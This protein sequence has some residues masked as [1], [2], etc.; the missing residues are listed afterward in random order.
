MANVF[1]TATLGLGVDTS[2]FI[3][4]MSGAVNVTKT[5]LNQMRLGAEA[6]ESQWN[7]MTD[8][9][10]D[11]R[12]IISG[13]L[14]SQGFYSLMNGLTFGA[15]EALT[16]AQ[17]MET[18]AVS[19]EYFVDGADKA[20]K[21][22]AF[23]REMN[24]FAARTPFSTEQALEMSKY[25]QAVG[26]SMNTSKA[27]LEVVTDAAAATGATEENL[28]RVIFA[29][30]QMQTKGRVANEEIRQLANANIPIY[31]ILQ[32]E[33][34]LTGDQISNIGKYWIDADKAIVAILRGLE[35][36]YDGAA[37]RI[38]D[39]MSGMIDTIADNS[40]IIAQAAGQGAYDGL[41]NVM[42]GVRDMLD[43][44]RDTVTEFGSA[45][46]FNQILID[47]DPTGE[48]GTQVLTLIG[49][50]RQLGAAAIDL[51]HAAQP[52]VGLFGK[53]LYAGVGSLTVGMTGL[54][55]VAEGVV[56]VLNELG[57]TSGTT[58]EVL[59][60]LYITYKVSRW[61]ISLGQGALFAMQGMYNAASGVWAIVP[62]TVTASS[63][64]MRLVG[65]LGILAAVG[66]AAFALFNNLD[67]FAGLEVDT[68]GMFPEDYN[69]A[70]DEYLAAMEEYNAAIEKY[71]Q[72][73]NAP[74]E[75]IDDGADKAITD[76]EDVED[77][78]KKAAK[79][80][81]KDWVAAFD[82][83]YQVPDQK[84]T[85]GGSGVE[86]PEMPDLGAFL[87]DLAFKFP[88]VGETELT[89]PE[90]PWEDVFS[91]GL[92]DDTAL[93]QDFWK[94]W[95]PG[96]I[97]MSL[98][99][100]AAMAAKKRKSRMDI[101]A[102]G[103][104]T[105]KPTTDMDP[106]KAQAKVQEAL[107]SQDK[108][109]KKIHS[110]TKEI[111]K[112]LNYAKNTSYG[113]EGRPTTGLSGTVEQQRLLI[114][115]YKK[116]NDTAAKYGAIVG[117]KVDTL[118]AIAEDERTLRSAQLLIN[119]QRLAAIERELKASGLTQGQMADLL[120]EQK[121]L[122]KE[123]TKL[124]QVAQGTDI[125]GFTAAE[126][127]Q[128]MLEQSSGIVTGLNDVLAKTLPRRGGTGNILTS[129][130]VKKLFSAIDDFTA[131]G[132]DL[133]KMLP[134]W[135]SSNATQAERL[136]NYISSQ[137]KE[138]ASIRK[139][140]LSGNVPAIEAL[141]RFT[142]AVTDI[143]TSSITGVNVRPQYEALVEPVQDAVNRLKS[144]NGYI[145]RL[146]DEAI[147]LNKQ[148]AAETA[149]RKAASEAAAAAAAEQQRIAKETAA[150]AKRLAAREA[151]ANIS[152]YPTGR[153][154]AGML[155]GLG[156]RRP[157]EAIALS[158]IIALDSRGVISQAVSEI[159]AG[160]KSIE[161]SSLSDTAS[162]KATLRAI[163]ANMQLIR[164]NGGELRKS[165]D[166][167]V[168][169]LARQFG[170]ELSDATAA[171]V[172]KLNTLNALVAGFQDILPSSGLASTAG[173]AVAGGN[174]PPSLTKLFGSIE[175]AT[176]VLL[177]GT[178]L[179]KATLGI[180]AFDGSDVDLIVKA[181]G[182][183]FP[184][185]KRL[186]K[187]DASFAVEIAKVMGNYLE[188]LVAFAAQ[189]QWQTA[190]GEV[191]RGGYKAIADG[192]AQIDTTVKYN[193]KLLSNDIKTVSGSAAEA[194]KQSSKELLGAVRSLDADML[195]LVRP[196]HFYQLGMQAAAFDDTRLGMTIFN[197][198][199][200]IRD[201]ADELY[202]VFIQKMQ[203]FVPDGRIFS[204]DAVSR[205]DAINAG[206][207]GSVEELV[208]SYVREV[209]LPT[210]GIPADAFD[211]ALSG[212][213]EEL[214]AFA[215]TMRKARLD[216]IGA[217][218]TPYMVSYSDAQIRALDVAGTSKAVKQ[219]NE[220]IAAVAH[221]DALPQFLHS[222]IIFNE[223]AGELAGTVAAIDLNSTLRQYRRM[224]ESATKWAQNILKTSEKFDA[225]AISRKL[226][227]A[228]DT[229]VNNYIYDVARLGSADATALTQKTAEQLRALAA[230]ARQHVN[231]AAS[232][233]FA[234]TSAT[235]DNMSLFARSLETLADNLSDTGR[236]ASL[237][238]TVTDKI[239]GINA[240]ID[241]HA[242]V[243]PSMQQ[244]FTG[245]G[246]NLEELFTLL[247]M[248]SNE[249]AIG[250][251]RQIEQYTAIAKQ[252]SGTQYFDELFG[253][254]ELPFHVASVKESAQ[255]T[256]KVLSDAVND[257]LLTVADGLTK[258]FTADVS[259]LVPDASGITIKFVGDLASEPLKIPASLFF[260]FETTDLITQTPGGAIMPEITQ[261][262]LLNEKTGEIYNW[263]IDHGERNAEILAR[264]QSI[265]GVGEAWRAYS[266]L[267]LANGVSLNQ[268]VQQIKGL[269]DSLDGTLTGYNAVNLIHAGGGFDAQLLKSLGIDLAD[270]FSK[271]VMTQAS[272]IMARYTGSYTSM[273][274]SSLYAIATGTQA[275][276][277]H[278]AA[279]DV[280][281]TAAIQQAITSGRFEQVV[282]NAAAEGFAG[283]IKNSLLAASNAITPLTTSPDITEAVVEQFAKQSLL[284]LP[285]KSLL[286]LAEEAAR[287]AQEAA[288]AAK[289][290]QAA[291]DTTG[292]AFK[293]ASEIGAD[294]AARRAAAGG[295]DFW[296]FLK[297][298]FNDIRSNGI[299]GDLSS[300]VKANFNTFWQRIANAADSW[301]D[302]AKGVE[303]IQS[304]FD[305]W[306]VLVKYNVGDASNPAN[307]VEGMSKLRAR[308]AA[309]EWA[310]EMGA[311]TPDTDWV[312]QAFKAYDDALNEYSKVSKSF[313]KAVT[314]NI[315]GGLQGFENN[316]LIIQAIDEL[317]DNAQYLAFTLDPKT[318]AMKLISDNLLSSK[319]EINRAFKQYAASFLEQADIPVGSI[320][321]F[322][323]ELLR[324]AASG[325]LDDLSDGA[326][327]LNNAF[328]TFGQTA[329]IY[330]VSDDLTDAAARI[331][332][333]GTG[334]ADAINSSADVVA[335]SFKNIGSKLINGIGG[336]GILDI[337]AVGIEGAFQ[338]FSDVNAGK[339]LQAYLSGSD[340]TSKIANTLAANGF[341]IGEEIGDNVYNAVGQ[342]VGQGLVVGIVGSLVASTAG[343][344][345]GSTIG[346]A[347]GSAIAPGVGTAVGVAIGA[348]V[349]TIAS[350]A[351]DAV[352][353]ATGGKTA[354]N[355]YLDDYI[356]QLNTGS[357]LT[358][359]M[360]SEAEAALGRAL[361][362]EEKTALEEQSRQLLTFQTMAGAKGGFWENDDIN[363]VLYGKTSKTNDVELALRLATALEAFDTSKIGTFTQYDDYSDTTS[364]YV[365][366]SDPDV[367]EQ[368][369]ELLGVE[370]ELKD[371]TG[372]TNKVL[373]DATNNR[374]LEGTNA[375]LEALGEAV[376]LLYTQ[377]NS[378]SKIT[379]E[380]QRIIDSNE[381]LSDAV[382]ESVGASTVMAAEAL[383][384]YLPIY[385]K[386]SGSHL[387]M[388]E[389]DE[390]AGLG[391][392]IIEQMTQMYDA[393]T[394]DY[395]AQAEARKT[396]T[397]NRDIAAGDTS[398]TIWG[399]NLAGVTQETLDELATFGIKLS[400][401]STTI[402]SEL[403]GA[404]E[405]TYVTLQTSADTI[406]E[407]LAGW[408]IDASN[409]AKLDF[410]QLTVTAEDAEILASAGIQINGD[411][412]VTFMK[413]ENAGNT[414]ATRDLML[415]ATSFSDSVIAALQSQSI[416]LDFEAKSLNFDT[417]SLQ[418]NLTGAMFK[419]PDNFS[420]YASEQVKEALENIG[421]IMDSGYFMITDQAVLNGNKTI[422]GYLDGMI[423]A[424]NVNSKVA[425]ALGNI[426]ALIHQEGA[427]VA[428][429]IAEWAD[430]IVMPS[431]IPEEEM[432]AEIEA[433]FAEIG[434]SF[435]EYAG[436]YMMIVN[437]AG[438]H[439][440]DG[441]TYV[442]KEKWMSLDASLRT[443]LE[444][445]GVT[446]TEVGNQVMVDL[447]GTFNNGINDVVNLFIA[448]P[449][450]WNQIPESVRAYLEQA[451]IVSEEGWLVLKNI[452][453]GKLTEIQGAWITL[454]DGISEDTLNTQI[455]TID[456][457]KTN[458]ATLESAVDDGLL[459]IAGVV[460]SS[461][462]PELTENQI[463]V[464][465]KNLPPEI[466]E[467][468]QGQ[469]GLKGKLEGSNIIL[470]NA[471]KTAFAGMLEELSNAADGA[472]GTA[473]EMAKTIE[474]AVVKAMQKIQQLAAL[475]S[476]LGHTGWG[477]WAK[478]NYL[479]SGQEVGEVTYYPEINSKGEVVKYWYFDDNGAR[480][481]TTTLPT[482]AKGGYAEGLTLTGELGREMA[483]LPDGSIKMLGANGRGELVNLPKGTR[484]LNNEDTEAVLKYAG[485]VSSISKLAEGNAD[486]T[487][488]KP[489][490]AGNSTEAT[491]V[492]FVRQLLEAY[493]AYLVDDSGE[494]GAE[495]QRDAAG[496]VATAIRGAVAAITEFDEKQWTECFDALDE[497]FDDVLTTVEE[498][499][500]N[501]TEAIGDLGSSISSLGSRLQSS[502]LSRPD[503]ISGAGSSGTV[504][505]GTKYPDSWY[506]SD[507][508]IEFATVVKDT[509]SV[510]NAFKELGYVKNENGAWTKPKGSAK[511]SLITKDALY[512]A[513]ELGL[514]EAIIPL[515]Q[516][517]VL[518]KVGSAI[519]GYVT[520]D[521]AVTKEDVDAAT[522]LLIEAW[523]VAV[524]G[525]VAAI[526]E[527]QANYTNELGGKIEGII[528]VVDEN[529][530]KLEALEA[531]ATAV[532]T[533]S[534][535][536]QQIS[537]EVQQNTETTATGFAELP[538]GLT[539][540]FGQWFVD[541]LAAAREAYGSAT[542]EADR[543]AAHQMAEDV[544]S[545]LGYSG[546]PDGSQYIPLNSSDDSDAL[547]GITEQLSTKLDANAA[548]IIAQLASIEKT[549]S[550]FY[551]QLL[552]S[553]TETYN[554]W[555]ATYAAAQSN[556]Q[557]IINAAAITV[558][559]AVGSYV[560]WS[561]NTISALQAEVASLRAALS[562]T[563]TRSTIKGSA[564]GSLVTKDALYRAG[565]LG[566]NEAI[567]PL[568]Q[569]SVMQQVGATIASYLPTS[570]SSASST[571]YSELF[572]KFDEQTEALAVA[573]RGAVA[574]VTENQSNY[575]TELFTKVEGIIDVVDENLGELESLDELTQAVTGLGNISEVLN[576]TTD[577]IIG[578][579]SEKLT[580][581][582]TTVTNIPGTLSAE[583]VTA[584][585]AQIAQAGIDYQNASSDDERMLAHNTAEEA[586]KV[587][588]Y[589]GG[590]DGSQYIPL[591]DSFN[592]NNSEALTELLTTQHTVIVECFSTLTEA[593][594]TETKELQTQF[595]SLDASLQQLNEKTATR[596]GGAA[597]DIVAAVQSGSL[598][599][600]NAV[601]SYVNWSQ[602]TIASLQR[603]VAALQAALAAASSKKGSASG[604]LITKDALYRAGEFGL[605]EAIIPL[606][607][608]DVLK[609]V[610]SAIA[611]F[612]PAERMQLRAVSGMVNAGVAA[613]RS[614]IQTQQDQMLAADSLAQRILEIVLPQIA[615]ASAPQD[616]EQRRP[617]Y[618]GN[619][620]ADEQGLKVLERKLYDIRRLE[621]TRR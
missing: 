357:V 185:L 95:L 336:F 506:T 319:T 317:S 481:S 595:K 318:G 288:D 347:I 229:L 458:L 80:V 232:E 384:D 132:D 159:K 442:D 342:A 473:N 355:L 234:G 169:A 403:T 478:D 424:E 115:E 379:S 411:G 476:E 4:G 154:L 93:S 427:T 42:T 439:L 374:Y 36:R 175:N 482:A 387:T 369:E 367:V 522:Q 416:A 389:V 171:V 619:L 410:S 591:Q 233:L 107:D 326:K 543:A 99:S 346:G 180:G 303:G 559:N 38:S 248:S 235:A 209:L 428:A 10:K 3:K 178:T 373:Y 206:R 130:D 177:S 183:A 555:S 485:P 39:T 363:K 488:A 500:D 266:V 257:G 289:N 138:L 174:L 448:Q 546:G 223:Q 352:I 32:E 256:A 438:E 65:T 146:T 553:D 520:T 6:F 165:L 282:K 92:L 106:K 383:A 612:I 141:E 45:G 615:Y 188:P 110:N 242:K 142:A 575:T 187:R 490:D 535:Y 60:Q 375:N 166:T 554:K 617:L 487:I 602:N 601:G 126:L 62:A 163:D 456:G 244:T 176:Q 564:K 429:N 56:G 217:A 164:D 324:A 466:Q 116:L 299:L 457:T 360:L 580:E 344:K 495:S 128:L 330:D 509:G 441:I 538:V 47:I 204:V 560:N 148:N 325:N 579:I 241:A 5:G 87:K 385:N 118:A 359:D 392:A 273:D 507:G 2:K 606:E 79:A 477:F 196:E 462:I 98:L 291:A 193:G 89:M 544:R 366:V 85:S 75:T 52:L 293:T 301:S 67:K 135:A 268:A 382:I 64:V 470:E 565:E 339:Q 413:A 195:K 420:A 451:G 37:D 215:D 73:F 140:L 613:P 251:M 548:S 51:Y 557:S 497:H 539:A 247:G 205:Y 479:G 186:T 68:G 160:I 338:H 502:M 86:L 231:G 354:T 508:S 57:I 405:Q 43:E 50:F 294:D 270:R 378:S 240:A 568:E 197:R 20:A 585:T 349:G 255:Y 88:S 198:D 228:V 498:A 390:T 265:D 599:V 94:S 279:T 381:A 515:E 492:G 583:V 69:N 284:A 486:L 463:A 537:S 422:Q 173:Q 105:A 533:L 447:G 603:Q 590:P 513:G 295:A 376:K 460:D 542:T 510:A 157:T 143:D 331:K 272:Q 358:A 181:F 112:N 53:S 290:V 412:T 243:L 370:L 14:I 435:E 474:D 620:I 550:T 471:T 90:F 372:S 74:Y 465:F 199:F 621:S 267:D 55:Q 8:G 40:K 598:T 305:A 399:A 283:G 577:K 285:E 371:L 396:D 83:V 329:V 505:S 100:A 271:D 123:N 245:L 356:A 220:L 391:A 361:T 168:R 529:L 27:F 362:A 584:L 322:Y 122:L 11:T 70:M 453:E 323:R 259:A 1:S 532:D 58:A 430:G 436:Q 208:D 278:N 393:I 77:A 280:Q 129:D 425:T 596:I 605:N 450:V 137:S 409:Y 263:L 18:A 504:S 230:E 573:I 572:T 503:Q 201:A 102:D 44:Y 167:H 437:Q 558:A 172:P 593:V 313:Y 13:I 525:A 71:Q 588:G 26:I 249:A 114:S 494:K 454:W 343:A 214:Q 327:A 117:S 113:I 499:S 581:I 24:E 491:L 547:T 461:E 224:S 190:G 33:L 426:D 49:D 308:K 191:M 121:K 151:A 386:V 518:D 139:A 551:D 111:T 552:K 286:T 104:L 440:Y 7:E 59:A 236:T 421:D 9:I 419:L 219:L 96:I 364:K 120:T 563:S 22:L 136:Y 597:S 521:T 302:A 25:I 261:F 91:G 298:L 312:K 594:S 237:L 147:A 238:R 401:A 530:G 519:G 484:V 275:S 414:G 333:A 616:E 496:V 335:G 239:A 162:I 155:D 149:A 78:S 397:W 368:L 314:E 340:S 540:E 16:F 395:L 156:I 145:S 182:D 277:A 576:S 221:N 216:V 320:D 72:Q 152:Y 524:R 19:M 443:A 17:N 84:D 536:I 365:T 192:V 307:L 614:T 222:Y 449:D 292:E 254:I 133:S 406:K 431:P 586:R 609:Q 489:E 467:A 189:Q 211:A 260:D 250:V 432:T 227:G 415:D 332:Y 12:R 179:G 200:D 127:K 21:S 574:A 566:L 592:T 23:L 348:A 433:A 103:S 526:T 455:E 125:S 545:L 276:G 446:V 28:Q 541:S 469:E 269:V 423:G 31:Q 561:Q 258:Q 418:E 328:N 444:D 404:I 556:L 527:N 472:G 316:R 225:G 41:K 274:L 76:I 350:F 567:I 475:S 480:R 35:K 607:R 445:L 15:S 434:V 514:N 61:M 296:G 97:S 345:L 528:D 407:N 388:A 48:V 582:D 517:D 589:S 66:T 600:A 30:G 101:N 124:V 512:R 511:G 203:T 297:G 377:G 341:N 309:A 400:E 252:L 63:G 610:G 315:A 459:K 81:Q 184:G 417:E 578:T 408:Q 144:I 150:A 161:A 464:P 54:A 34:N 194:Y 212:S 170:V 452:G 604:S 253:K 351:T 321:D 46:L 158:D 570:Y 134:S 304:I 108:L 264:M 562:S 534:S 218:T 109:L 82:E 226:M 300:E 483:V 29:L 287:A 119:K 618:V 394:A 402:E 523:A 493:Q 531:L 380:L 306:D 311:V 468:L 246:R 353:R 501:V 337:A 153:Q 569:P 516:P 213:V 210:L 207:F 202:N 281:M 549:G 310:V 262:S 611:S 571:S 587:L 334:A 131:V 398:T 608:P